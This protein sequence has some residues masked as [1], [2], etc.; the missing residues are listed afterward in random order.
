MIPRAFRFRRFGH[1]LL[2]LLLG[3]LFAALATTNLIVSRSNLANAR[4]NARINLERAARITS[5]SVR[6]RLDYFSASASMMSRDDAF[7]QVLRTGDNRTLASALQ[8]YTRQIGA[9]VISLYDAEGKFL[10]DSR[11]E[12][13]NENSGPF[14]YLTRKAIDKDMPEN[15]G[16]S[17]LRDDSKVDQLHALLVV[18]LYAPYP[19]VFGWFGLAF[20]IASSL[21]KI[22]DISEVELTYVAVDDLAHPRVLATTLPAASLPAVLRFAAEA[23]RDR[24][25]LRERPVTELVDL[26]D[27]RYVTLIKYQE[28]LGEDPV[29]LVLQRPLTPE[30]ASARELENYIRLTSL[31]TLAAATLLALFVS[32]GVSEPVRQLAAH[33]EK[34]AT[35]DYATRIKLNRADEL[36]Q[37]ADAMN[38]MSVGLDER[39]RVR[40]LLDKNV[41]PEVAAQLLRDG[42]AL[43]GQEREVTILFSDLRNFTTLS[44]KLPPPE[45]LALLN[46]YFTRMTGPIEQHGGVIDKFIGDSI[47]A[48]FGAPIAHPE[49]ADH[50]VAAALAMQAAL[51][52]LNRELA[53]DGIAPLGIGIGINTGKV[54]AGQMGS[55]RRLNYSVIGDGVNV[56]SRLQTLTRTAEYRT[57]L[58]VSAA[59]VAALREPAKFKVRALGTVPVKGRAKPVE[60]FAVD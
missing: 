55:E 30:L 35:G 31:A 40:D 25:A 20:P 33:T 36:G 8:S 18:P 43:G 46:R 9:S 51:V 60:I 29:A 37:L 59:T 57:S 34:I 11:S 15:T 32:R 50:A 4:E 2:A 38:Q 49:S 1:R 26:P 16:F 45:L 52:E 7:K 27:D 5:S 54:V 53:A 22:R 14:R 24:D 21:Q 41:S 56:A 44:E 58:I 47:M 17:Y 10:A 28:M 23:K 19:N 6:Q 13:E 12:V 48:L 39:D 3:L 42:A